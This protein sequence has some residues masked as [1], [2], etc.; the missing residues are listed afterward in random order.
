MPHTRLANLKAGTKGVVL[1]CGAWRDSAGGSNMSNSR[2]RSIVHR[3]ESLELRRLFAT[4]PWV[5]R[6]DRSFDDP[7]KW[8][9]GTVPGPG[10]QVVITAGPSE[11]VTVTSNVS[12]D[13]LPLGSESG[14]GAQLEVDGA[15]VTASSVVANPGTQLV[16]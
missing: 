11:K 6:E 1:L 7:T 15:S 12:V 2:S 8:S 9:S 16:L 14:S 4:V 5:Q 10:D 13:S 3:V